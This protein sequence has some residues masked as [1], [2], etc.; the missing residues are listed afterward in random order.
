[1]SFRTR[2]TITGTKG[3]YTLIEMLVALA[4]FTLSAVMIV[5]TITF[6]YRSNSNSI[7]QAFALAS[8]RKGVDVMIRDI[9]EAAY[10]DD[11][12][13]PVVWM[14]TNQFTFYSDTDRDAAV[15][16]IRYFLSGTDLRRG[17]I[18]PTG[19]PPTYNVNN[20]V[21]SYVSDNIRNSEQGI[22]IFRFYDEGGTEISA[23]TSVL[24]LKFVSVNLIVNIN[25][26]RLPEEFTLRSSA[27]LRNLKTN[28]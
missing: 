8:A 4:I 20:E 27:T 9:R 5:G 16:R 14:S 19:N 22:P 23:T 17:V 13:F 25:P 7:E 21:V 3:G 26:L 24:D 18:E 2:Y 1:M 10:A 15:E 28:L 11:G 6:L 12:S